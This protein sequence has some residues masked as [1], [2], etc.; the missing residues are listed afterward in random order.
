MQQQA[1]AEQELA[2]ILADPNFP[3]NLPARA[4]VVK[5]GQG[6]FR[7]STTCTDGVRYLK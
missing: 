5:P 2:T 1:L 6:T 4:I 7:P 3:D